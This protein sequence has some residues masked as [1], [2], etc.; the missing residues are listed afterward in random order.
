M[1]IKKK[2]DE[3]SRNLSGEIKEEMD[4]KIALQKV[5]LSNGMRRL[6]ILPV[7]HPTST[8]G[9][10]ELNYCVRDENRWILRAIVTAMD[11]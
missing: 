5:R 11:I 2:K 7:G 9:A 3:M 4:K 1:S 10:A 6:P 8:F